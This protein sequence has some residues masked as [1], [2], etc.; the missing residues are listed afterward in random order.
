MD[1]KITR[2][3]Y[4]CAT[5]LLKSYNEKAV[6]KGIAYLLVCLKFKYYS[7]RMSYYKHKEK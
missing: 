3:E 6:S 7:V 4:M 2:S 1:E 5:N